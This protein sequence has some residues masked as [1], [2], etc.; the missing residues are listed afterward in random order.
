MLRRKQSLTERLYP[1]MIS[2]FPRALNL[3]RKEAFCAFYCCFRGGAISV[4]R[5]ETFRS[6]G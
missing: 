3:F 6:A 2:R 5:L 1:R 4:E